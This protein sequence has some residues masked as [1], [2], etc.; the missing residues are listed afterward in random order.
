[1]KI[2]HLNVAKVYIFLK[3]ILGGFKNCITCGRAYKGYGE[4]LIFMGQSKK[5]SIMV[6]DYIRFTF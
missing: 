6:R 2:S 5:W 1:M 3:F 4:P